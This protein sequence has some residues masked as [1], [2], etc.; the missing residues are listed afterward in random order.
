[1]AKNWKKQLLNYFLVA[2]GTFV[3]AFGTV[4]FLTKDE[5]VAGGLSGIAIIIQHFVDVNI[6]D[7]LI[8]GLTVLFW[9]IGLVFCGKDFAFKTLFSSLLYIGFTFL[10]NRIEFFDTLANSF[11]GLDNGSEPTAG[12]YI[13]CGIFGGVF[14]G[15][16]IAITFLGGG[17]TGGVD[18]LQPIGK[19]F[20][21]IPEP[22]T[23]IAVDAVVIIVGMIAMQ[24]W[25]PALCGILSCVVTAALIEIVYIRNQTSYMADIISDKWEEINDFAQKELDRGTTIIHA[26]GGYQG[27]DRVVLRI[28]FDKSQYEKLRS[29][30][31]EIDPKAFMTFTQTNAVYGEGFASHKR[32]I[33]IK[34]K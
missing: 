31:A 18:C 11:A 12:N 2:V 5:L 26:K 21:N 14:V 24:T 4:V 19:R 28:V 10:F 30:I 32:K 34:K 6:Y 9:I 7:Y 16:G 27:A 1:M 23:S 8:A 3:L 17:S 25:I 15:T 33:K 29:K 22:I 13:L 20:F